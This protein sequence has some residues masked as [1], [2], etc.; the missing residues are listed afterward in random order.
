MST[1]LCS[2][3]AASFSPF[4]EEQMLVFTPRG[5][6]TQTQHTTAH[7]W[8]RTSKGTQTSR[9]KKT[10]FSMSPASV[11]AQGPSLHTA[12]QADPADLGFSQ[13]D[14]RRPWLLA[15][16]PGLRGII[17]SH[18]ATSHSSASNVLRSA[19]LSLLCSQPG[20]GPSHLARTREL[21]AS[22]VQAGES[23]GAAAWRPADLHD[24][25]VPGGAREPCQQM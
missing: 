25:T 12:A 16:H 13:A 20:A 24:L 7:F 23:R 2:E 19:C 8:T 4:P 11:S 15:A 17:Q 6:Q 14:P 3:D 5:R 22:W 10:K 9:V 21:G 1:S 18:L